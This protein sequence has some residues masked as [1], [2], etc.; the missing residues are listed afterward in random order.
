MPS[1]Y[2]ITEPHPTAQNYIH[3]GRGGVGNTFKAPAT[4]NGINARGPA[5]LFE[6]GLPQTSG[7]FSSGRGGAGNIRESSEKA[8]F[9]FDEE[10]ERQTTRDQKIKEGA[11]WHVGRGGAGNWSTSQAVSG[12]K[13][14]TSST[15][16]DASTRSGFF[17]RL[18]SSLERH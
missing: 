18:S 12:R 14:S 16:S 7:R 6:T 11:V 17:S 10:L 15:G 1:Q 5:S 3:S 2:Q 9:S 4:T 8:I 13:S